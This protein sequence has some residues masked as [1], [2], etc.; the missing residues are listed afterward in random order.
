MLRLLILILQ[1]IGNT[2]QNNQRTLN[3]KPVNNNGFANNPI[4]L[5]VLVAIAMLIF[6]GLIFLCVPCT[7]SGVYY[8]RPL[9]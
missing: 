2:P 8:N 9:Y 7:E 6:T 4:I 1:L 3:P 5:L